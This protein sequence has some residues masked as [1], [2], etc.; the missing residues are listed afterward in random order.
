MLLDSIGQS[1][2]IT[3][4]IIGSSESL[5]KNKIGKTGL[6]NLHRMVQNNTILTILN[7]QNTSLMN[8]GLKRLAEGF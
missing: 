4:A 8:I 6:E 5:N 2:T 3:C 1:K 7:L